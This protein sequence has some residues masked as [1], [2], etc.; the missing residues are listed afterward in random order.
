MIKLRLKKMRGRQ[1]RF[2]TRQLFNEVIN[3]I[4]NVKVL[5]RDNDGNIYINQIDRV[6]MENRIIYLKQ[7]IKPEEIE[8]TIELGKEKEKD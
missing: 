5:C 7:A 1:Y 2:S 8:C 3:E 6:D 4:T